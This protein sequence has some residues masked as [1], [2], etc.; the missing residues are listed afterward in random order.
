MGNKVSYLILPE[1][2]YSKIKP[3]GLLGHL[4]G[5]NIELQSYHIL[6]EDSKII[7]TKHIEFLDF[8][9]IKRDSSLDDDLE[10]ILKTEQAE[11][12]ESIYDETEEKAGK[13]KDMLAK[14]NNMEHHDVWE[15]R[16]DTI[17]IS[18]NHLGFHDSTFYFI[19]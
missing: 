1:Q 19:I 11:N 10:S 3:N 4:I 16:F 12:T 15:D 9:Q 14:P 8:K 13:A 7:E 6:A 18:E 5:Y 2:S 17:I